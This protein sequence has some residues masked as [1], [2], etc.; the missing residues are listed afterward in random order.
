MCSNK[1]P[2]GITGGSCALLIGTGQGLEL[3]H[4][5][6]ECNAGDSDGNILVFSFAFDLSARTTN[7][8]GSVSFV[9]RGHEIC[10]VLFR[11]E[12]VIRPV[13]RSDDY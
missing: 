1:T 11:H 4:G 6:M 8:D 13:S 5:A 9:A 3:Q 7:S 2:G 10:S 12:Q